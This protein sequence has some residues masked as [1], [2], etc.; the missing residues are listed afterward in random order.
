ML[1]KLIPEQISKLWPIIKYA[2]EQ[3][4]PPMAGDHPEKMNR[5]LSSALCGK[6]DIWASYAKKDNVNK[7][8]GIVVTEVLYDDASGIKNLL[9][10]SV[11][12]YE[13]TSKSTWI[14]GLATLAK[15][16][17]SLKCNNI[18]AYSSEKDI[19]DLVKRLGGDTSFTFLSFGI[20][21]IV[22][23]LNGLGGD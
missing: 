8:E 21:E 4:V 12:G 13:K 17:K 16:G 19:I 10:Y 11:F 23:K 14:T 20:D 2:I 5:I 22:Q 7:F 15:Y 3:S 9:I 18:V 6:I 1:T